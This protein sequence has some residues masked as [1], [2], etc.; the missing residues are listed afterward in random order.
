MTCPELVTVSMED[1]QGLI[2]EMLNVL[3]QDL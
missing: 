1:W 3:G 2:K